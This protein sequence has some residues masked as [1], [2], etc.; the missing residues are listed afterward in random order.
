MLNASSLRV[1]NKFKSCFGNVQTVLS[2]IDNTNKGEIKVCADCP[3][4]VPHFKNEEHR[5]MYSHL[6]LCEENGNQYKPCEIEGEPLT[7]EWLIKFGFYR[8]ALDMHKLYYHKKINVRG[9]EEDF[10][11]SFYRDGYFMYCNGNEQNSS[12]KTKYFV[13]EL[14]NLYFSLTGE[15]LIL[16]N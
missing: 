15:E 3:D 2:I 8:G 6:I 12:Y 9:Y 1:G 5:L 14:Q 10:C 16:I 7:E 11:I 13:H 4:S